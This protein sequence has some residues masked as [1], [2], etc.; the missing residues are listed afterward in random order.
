MRRRW[1]NIVGLLTVAAALAVAAATYETRP[2]WSEKEESAAPAAPLDIVVRGRLEPSDGV[3]EVAAFSLAPTTAV[4]N[5][6]VAEGQAVRK[7]ELVATLRSHAQAL[8]GIES[9]KA[10]LTIAERRLELTRRPY[11]ESTL[12]A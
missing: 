3:F 6:L 2:R 9:A 5:I 1:R 4:G 8:A 12:A 11:K 10:A 7:G